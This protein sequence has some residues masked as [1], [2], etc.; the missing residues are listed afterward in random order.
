MKEPTITYLCINCGCHP[1]KKDRGKSIN[2]AAWLSAEIVSMRNAIPELEK[3]ARKT[4]AKTMLIEREKVAKAKTL[5]IEI[6]NRL[7]EFLQEAQLL[8]AE[9]GWAPI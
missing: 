5:L 1:E 3:Q 4:P 6:Q 8:R 2:R 7:A 9:I